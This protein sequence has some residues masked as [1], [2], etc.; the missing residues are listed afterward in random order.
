M[1]MRGTSW[2]RSTSASPKGS[3][4]PICVL[5]ERCWS[6]NLSSLR[7]VAQ[8]GHVQVGDKTVE[9]ARRIGRKEGFRPVEGAARHG[10][11]LKE[12]A[13]RVTHCFVIVDDGNHWR[14]GQ[15]G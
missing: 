1:T 6:G 12:P 3:I 10:E 4:R 9:F 15:D 13:K 8:A 14:I 5:Q 11:H 2:R 7:L